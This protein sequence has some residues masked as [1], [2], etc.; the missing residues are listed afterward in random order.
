MIDYL[1]ATGY[2]AASGGQFPILRVTTLGADVLQGK[3]KVS[4]KISI[5]A[6]KALSEM[7]TYLKAFVS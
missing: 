5:K 7:M 2:L 3:E 1:T 4:R 6:T